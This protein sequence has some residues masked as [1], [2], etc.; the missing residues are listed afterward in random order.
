MAMAVKDEETLRAVTMPTD[1]LHWLLQGQDVP[2]EHV[3]QVKAQMAQQPIRALKPGDVML[4]PGNRKL[5]VQPESVTDDKAL[6]LLQGDPYP[7][8]VIRVDG[9]W[10]VDARIIIATRKVAAGKTATDK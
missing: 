2:P 1:E 7:H 3:E 5:T 4:L 6:L 8:P 9:K 10:R